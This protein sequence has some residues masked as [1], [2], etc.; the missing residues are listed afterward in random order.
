MS[1]IC[2]RALLHPKWCSSLQFVR[3]RKV[4]VQ[5]PAQPHYRKALVLK[6]CTPEYVDPK[7][8]MSLADLC[9][10]PLEISLREEQKETRY[11]RFLAKEVLNWF[12]NSN[13]IAFY[14]VNPIPGGDRQKARITFK[15]DNMHMKQ[16]GRKVM[17]MALQNTK[18]EAVLH[19]FTSHN[20]IVFS[21]ETQ[22]AKLL[23]ISKKI[24]QLIL[25]T[26]VVDGKL[27]S[28]NELIEY[29]KVPNIQTAQAG[30]VAVLNSGA[31][32][33]NQNLVHHQQTLVANLQKHIEMQQDEN[34][35]K[36]D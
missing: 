6:V 35:N 22:V 7:E 27:L 5:K 17:K 15:R 26:A 16:Y 34:S 10:K 1:A 11:E 31:V 9:E 30:L 25:M 4:V 21:P 29:S 20:Y 32:Q 23:K 24:P 2:S 19:L 14:H 33:L 8:G 12:N 36:D 13:M 28:L 18:Y 3:F